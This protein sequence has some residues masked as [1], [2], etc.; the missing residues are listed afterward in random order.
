M[1]KKKLLWVDHSYHIVTKSA[2]FYRD[3]LQ[4]HFNITDY[5]VDPYENCQVKE[6]FYEGCFS[7]IEGESFDVVVLLQLLPP[8]AKVSKI[9]YRKLIFVPMY[10]GAP[11]RTDAIWQQYKNIFTVVC[12]SKTLHEELQQLGV[13]S[14]YIQYF[15]EPMKIHDWGNKD[16]V[17][18][19]QR[20]TAI[21]VNTVAALFQGHGIKRF[22]VHKAV[23]PSQNFVE[24]CLSIKEDCIFSEWY[25]D[26]EMMLR[27]MEKCAIYIAPRFYEGI[28]MSFL[29][30][31][32][33]GRCVVAANNPTMNEYITHSKNG[34]L[35]DMDSI[36]PIESFNMREIQQN[37]YDYISDGF[38]KYEQNKKI[39]LHLALE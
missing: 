18:F 11:D 15:P 29:E 19:W 37:A 26:K 20:L 6:D 3:S 36:T 5:F 16:Y 25:E 35:F 31:M 10:D 8:L 27:D 23:D 33:M 39:F 1:S 17:F 38:L 22:Y 12:F 4:K 34:I 21:N 14:H 7:D 30:A 32:A 9:S 28:G 24:P 13:N 2:A